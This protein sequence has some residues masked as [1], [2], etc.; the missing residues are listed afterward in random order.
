MRKLKFLGGIETFT[1]EQLNNAAS[2]ASQTVTR[3][4]GDPD[5]PAVSEAEKDALRDLLGY[6]G[7]TTADDPEPAPDGL[8]TFPLS[9]YTTY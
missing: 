7:I 9:S 8:T 6:L 1:Q 5:T 4:E 3:A 2:V